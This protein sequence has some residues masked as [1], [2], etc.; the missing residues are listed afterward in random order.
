[1]DSH[2][3]LIALDDLHSTLD[4]AGV[5]KAFVI[6]SIRKGI[7]NASSYE[8]LKRVISEQGAQLKEAVKPNNSLTIKSANESNRIIP[9][10]WI[11]PLA[12][13]AVEETVKSLNKGARGIKFQPSFHG[14]SL[15]DDHVIRVVNAAA[16]FDAPVF[17]HTGGDV[18]PLTARSLIER[19]QDVPFVMMH[20]GMFTHYTDAIALAMEYDN[21]HLDTAEPLPAI[22]VEIAVERLGPERILMGSDFPFWGHPKLAVEKVNVAVKEKK[23]RNMIMG[24]NAIKLVGDHG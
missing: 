23:S 15:D 13:D 3:H 19:F 1:V 24:G 7:E 10:A 14:Y 22:A 18:P 11:N 8:N 12:N 5:D 21:V 2:V 9:I 20:M 17:I 4:A 16:D 6:P